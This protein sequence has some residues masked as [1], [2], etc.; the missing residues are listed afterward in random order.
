MEKCRFCGK[1]VYKG[2]DTCSSCRR[3]KIKKQ[4]VILPEKPAQKAEI[5]EIQPDFVEEKKVKQISFPEQKTEVPKELFKPLYVLA[6]R[7]CTKYN[8]D[9]LTDEEIDMHSEALT[10]VLEKYMPKVI[11][12]NA[13]A[14]TLIFCTVTIAL[15][16]II[17]YSDNVKKAK[18][19]LRYM[20]QEREIQQQQQQ[21]IQQQQQMQQTAEASNTSSSI[22]KF[23]AQTGAR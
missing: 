6:N 23:M 22:D 19:Q 12:K 9:P 11:E 18:E 21:A 1:K 15:P 13:D 5:L 16:R 14:A 2:N 17:Q 20:Q 7:F 10:K 8:V 3:K 4:E